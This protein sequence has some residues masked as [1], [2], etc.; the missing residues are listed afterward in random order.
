VAVEIVGEINVSSRL[1]LKIYFFMERQLLA[2]KFK[3]HLAVIPG[4]LTS[5]L[6]LWT[7]QLINRSRD[8]C[9]RTGRSG[10]RHQLI[11]LHRQEEINVLRFPMFASGEKFLATSESEIILSH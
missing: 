11:T 3:K 6:S 10:L 7:F 4:G 1:R 5:Q 2:T 9:M 8:L